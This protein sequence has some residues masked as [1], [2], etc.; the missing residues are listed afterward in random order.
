MEKSPAAISVSES[1]MM[2]ETLSY[3]ILE[4]NHHSLKGDIESKKQIIVQI[5]NVLEPK[6]EE[7]KKINSSLESDIFFAFN[8]MNLRHNNV[9]PN[10]T[11]KYKEVIFK[12]SS[13]DL[14]YWYD[15]IYQMC[16]L[17]VLELEQAE[18]RIKFGELKKAIKGGQPL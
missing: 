17:S 18:R 4:Y 7:L 13:G 11:G 15:E 5:A 14:E 3:Q 9:D 12:M 8:N 10:D 16:L 6:R 2:P 1:Q